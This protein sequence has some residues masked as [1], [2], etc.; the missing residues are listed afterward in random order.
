MAIANVHR[1]TLRVNSYKI[2]HIPT[3][4]SCLPQSIES[5][6]TDAT[7]DGIAHLSPVEITPRGRTRLHG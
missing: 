7:K 2:E 5:R 3:L 6:R 1:H 4:P